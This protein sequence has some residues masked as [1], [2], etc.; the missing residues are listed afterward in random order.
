MI[1]C[2]EDV[3]AGGDPE[4]LIQHFFNFTLSFEF[5]VLL[6]HLAG[7]SHSAL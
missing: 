1:L 3:E 5:F 4:S 7:D 2:A 6:L